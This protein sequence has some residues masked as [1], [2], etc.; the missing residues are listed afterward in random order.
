MTPSSQLP[1]NTKLH[2]VLVEVRCGELSIT[3]SAQ[4]PEFHSTL[5][6]VHHL[7]VLDHMGSN[8]HGSQQ[9]HPHIPVVVVDEQ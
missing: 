2:E 5:L 7:N 4:S 6:L 9:H 1:L 3:V 8:V